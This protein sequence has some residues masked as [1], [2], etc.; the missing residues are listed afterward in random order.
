MTLLFIMDIVGEVDPKYKKWSTE[1][2]LPT[3]TR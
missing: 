1:F 3:A 2:R